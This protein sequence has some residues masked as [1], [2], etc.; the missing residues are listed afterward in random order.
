ML[1]TIRWL[2]R[3][4]GS[5]NH[6]M[7]CGDISESD[8]KP[9]H[10]LKSRKEPFLKVAVEEDELGS[11]PIRD[12]SSL[13]EDPGFLVGLVVSVLTLLCLSI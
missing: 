5:F 8:V 12:F 1:I 9:F 7:A 10:G 13:R 6:D 2:G 3:Q 11:L 4:A